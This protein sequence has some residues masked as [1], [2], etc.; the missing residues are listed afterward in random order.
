MVETMTVTKDVSPRSCPIAAS[1]ETLGERWMLLAIRELAYGVHR[2]EQI[3]QNTGASRDKLADRLR[4]LEQAGVVERRQY[5]ERP[6]R[7]EYHLTAAGKELAPVLLGLAVWGAKWVWDSPEESI[8][9]DSCGHP[10]VVDQ[11][12]RHCGG[13]VSR[14]NITIP[15]A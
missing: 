14:E 2:F 1:L 5:N 6:P 8:V 4:K 13:P 7:F 9:H 11:T 3:V 15:G 12:C 10:L